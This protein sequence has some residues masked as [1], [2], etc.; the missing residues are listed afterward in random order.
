[1]ELPSIITESRI[2]LPNVRLR[3]SNNL[4]LNM[5]HQLQTN[6][7]WAAVATSVSLF[8]NP[9]SGWVQ[10]TLVNSELEQ[11]A[12]C[13]NGSSSTCNK[14]WYLNRALMRTGSLESFKSG[15]INYTT[16]KQKI[17]NRLVIGVRI[18]W[19]GG[20]GHVVILDGYNT[21]GGDFLSVRDPWY[22]SST[23]TY[24]SFRSRYQGGGSWTHTYYT[25][26]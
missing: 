7:C 10:C 21:N 15:T 24:S 26:P 5:Q 13:R 8:Y 23:Y 3:L 18:G 14:P 17:D 16:L 4:N 1:M 22:G 20:G 11:F 6:W 12:C 2:K 19:S 25:K 9:G